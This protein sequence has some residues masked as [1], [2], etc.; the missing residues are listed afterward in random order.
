MDVRRA[1]RLLVLCLVV[2]DGDEHLR[3]AAGSRRTSPTYR[4]TPAL[5]LGPFPTTGQGCATVLP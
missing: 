3:A 4:L 2:C 1:A 5:G